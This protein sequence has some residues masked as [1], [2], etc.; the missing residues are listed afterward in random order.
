MVER[1]YLPAE[2][3]APR[4]MLRGEEARRHRH[5]RRPSERAERGGSDEA[6]VAQ[7]SGGEG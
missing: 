3:L 6:P 5:A 4:M 1:I 7:D 2:R